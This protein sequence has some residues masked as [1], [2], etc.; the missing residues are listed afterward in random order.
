MRSTV[1]MST[2]NSLFFLTVGLL[3][4]SL[5]TLVPGFFPP[6]AIYGA[7]TSALWISFMGSVL[8]FLGVVF[9]AANEV[10]PLVRPSLEWP[11]Q[12]VEAKLP[13]ALVLRPALI[14]AVENDR[15]AASKVAA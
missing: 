13:V 14:M 9:L 11:P 1:R 3:M 15:S 6:H 7:S 2:N 5:P 10:W 12:P 4:Y 8:S